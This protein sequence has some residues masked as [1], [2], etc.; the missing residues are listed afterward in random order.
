[1]VVVGLTIRNPRLV[2]L[3]TEQ[4]LFS[5]VACTELS[6]EDKS[7]GLKELPRKHYGNIVETFLDLKDFHDIY[8]LWEGSNPT[9]FLNA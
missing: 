4:F 1:M 3:D 2:T 6:F 7:N 8:S 5:R 9:I